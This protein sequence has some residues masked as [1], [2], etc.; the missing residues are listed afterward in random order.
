MPTRPVADLE[1]LKGLP[2]AMNQVL[3]TTVAHRGARRTRPAPSALWRRPRT[4][5]GGPPDVVVAPTVPALATWSSVHAGR[6]LSGYELQR[7]SM[8]AD[9]RH[10]GYCR[11]HPVNSG[12]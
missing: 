12:N 3:R 8:G 9:Y 10:D 2:A 4:R 6:N 7:A 11:R 1:H 5:A